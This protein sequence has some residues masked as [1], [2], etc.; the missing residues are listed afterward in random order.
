MIVSDP[1]CRRL[2]R[3][4]GVGAE[5]LH[6]WFFARPLGQSQL[7]GSWLPIWDDLLPEYPEDIAE[8]D[9]ATVAHALVA[10]YGGSRTP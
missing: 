9:A 3:M 2:G 6:L 7:Y 4:G 8:A 10:S 1:G 5:H